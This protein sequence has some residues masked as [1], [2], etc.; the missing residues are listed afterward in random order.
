MQENTNSSTNLLANEG[1]RSSSISA[2]LEEPK[3]PSIPNVTSNS[4]GE[5]IDFSKA[6]VRVHFKDPEESMQNF[7]DLNQSSL[8]RSAMI[9]STEPKSQ[10][11]DHSHN[12]FTNFQSDAEVPILINPKS[13]TERCFYAKE[14][15]NVLHDNA[16]NYMNEMTLITIANEACSFT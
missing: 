11:S 13:I 3:S 1:N 6:N 2:T 5:Y 9:T 15:A 10:D 12:L 8:R 14:V 16:I 7:I 4:E